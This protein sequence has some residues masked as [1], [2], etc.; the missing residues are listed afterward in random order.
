MAALYLRG[1][2]PTTALRQRFWYFLVAQLNLSNFAGHNDWRIP[3]LTEL[4]SIV[5]TSAPGCG[6][7]LPFP[8][9]PA[10]FNNNCT[11]GCTVNDLQLHRH[12]RIL[13][14]YYRHRPHLGA[15]FRMDGGLQLWQRIQ[16][17]QGGPQLRRRAGSAV[18]LV[19]RRYA[20]KKTPAGKDSVRRRRHRDRQRGGA[21]GVTVLCA[22][23]CSVTRTTPRRCHC[24]GRPAR[25]IRTC[26]D[27]QVSTDGGSQ[28]WYRDTNDP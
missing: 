11:P 26:T 12:G 21:T 23:G 17:R 19:I 6:V 16:R 3:T 2:E 25:K 28:S 24:A 1:G 4:Q 20:A 13:D 22:L 9:A 27:R 18:G 10:A 8:C 7:F 5:D 15:K 14:G